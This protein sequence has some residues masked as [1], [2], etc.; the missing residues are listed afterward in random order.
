MQHR[1]SKP[2]PPTDAI[3]LSYTECML[4]DAITQG[5]VL[6][7]EISACRVTNWYCLEASAMMLGD[8]LLLRNL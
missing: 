3:M 6:V 4:S 2:G 5:R 1:H 7:G 8:V